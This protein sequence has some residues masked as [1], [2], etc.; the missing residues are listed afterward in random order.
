MANPHHV[1]GM[2]YAKNNPIPRSTAAGLEKIACRTR[3]GEVELKITLTPKFL[4]KP[5]RDALI[6]PF[7]KVHNKRAAAPVSWEQIVCIK[8]DGM[9]LDT[10]AAADSE[11]CERLLTKEHVH[12]VLLTSLPATL[13]DALFEVAR[14]F[15]EITYENYHS[16]PPKPM[17][18]ELIRIARAASD[19]EGAAPDPDA[20]RRANNAFEHV[21]G[22]DAAVSSAQVRA[23][24]LRDEYVRNLCFP[25]TSA[26]T[27]VLSDKVQR[28]SAG[29]GEPAVDAAEFTRFFVALSAAACAPVT[30]IDDPPDPA[31]LKKQKDEGAGGFLQQLM[32]DESCSVKRIH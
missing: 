2:G 32:D 27:R 18:H 28:M 31:A 8:V 6:E 20:L 12:V 23:A 4:L 25:S 15:E 14:E 13:L 10:Q 11:P 16:Q 17:S 21:S 30:A 7:L 24:L 9:T 22:G 1:P 5:L 29:A 3:C 19:V 26:H